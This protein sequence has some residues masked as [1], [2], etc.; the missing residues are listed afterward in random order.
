M[1]MS[2]LFCF[3]VFN[4]GCRNLVSSSTAKKIFGSLTSRANSGDYKSCL[5]ESESS[6]W[7]DQLSDLPV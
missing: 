6:V 2:E 7:L 5:S 4:L 3:T 1:K